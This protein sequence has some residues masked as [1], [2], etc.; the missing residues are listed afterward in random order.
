MF[1]SSTTT[2]FTNRPV[3]RRARVNRARTVARDASKLS[4]NKLH[5]RTQE[6]AS[7]A[8]K[9]T[10]VP[11]KKPLF[12]DV[13]PAQAFGA[14]F[15]ASA[16]VIKSHIAAKSGSK[17]RKTR[18]TLRYFDARG[19]AEVIRTIFAAANVDYEDYRYTFSMDGP[20]PQICEQ[21]GIDKEA[22]LFD[23]N[24]QRLPVLEVQGKSIGQ[25]RAIE[26]FLAKDLGLM[27]KGKIEE[28]KIDAICEHVRD[29]RDAYQKAR[30]NPFAP[31]TP[32]I[33]EAMTK[34]YDETMKMW[35]S[36]LES[37][38]G[39]EWCVGKKMSLADIVLYVALTQAFNDA[40]KAAA[41][42]ADCPRVSAIVDKVGENA[43]IQKW[44]EKRPENRF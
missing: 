29:L 36:K 32:E 23:E 14:G 12:A 40:E 27:G 37:V 4:P 6:I 28:A 5:E 22:G 33:E 1:A 41:S 3:H 39:D 34:W 24:L 11:V 8:A 31:M 2:A 42:Y 17:L 25:S 13:S 18:A 16:A 35:M 43:G 21:H 7:I 20:K 19:A 9:P 38:V 30:G 26:R 10:P 15:L 44:L